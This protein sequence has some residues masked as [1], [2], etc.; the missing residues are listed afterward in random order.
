MEQ[1]HSS[2]QQA[3]FVRDSNGDG[4][5]D[6]VD[7]PDSVLRELRL[8]NGMPLTPMQKRMI[9]GRRAS[10]GTEGAISFIQKVASGAAAAGTVAHAT[11]RASSFRRTG[12][13]SVM[14]E[15]RK[16]KVGEWLR[17]FLI[18]DAVVIIGILYVVLER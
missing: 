6:I 14:S 4:V 9:K 7:D 5:P 8:P 13:S 17:I 2:E 11:K 16:A 1:Q 10:L 15:E 3:L 18:I 12:S